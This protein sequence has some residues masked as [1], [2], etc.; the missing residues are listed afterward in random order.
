MKFIT[1]ATLMLSAGAALGK[2]GR[3]EFGRSKPIATLEVDRQLGGKGGKSSKRDDK[4]G[5]YSSKSNKSSHSSSKSMKSSHIQHV[6]AP[7]STPV[8]SNSRD[9]RDIKLA[10]IDFGVEE[11]AEAAFTMQT[12]P[13]L[14]EGIAKDYTGVPIA[15][16]DDFFSRTNSDTDEETR[17]AF[18]EIEDNGD[19]SGLRT[20]NM[21][22]GIA[23]L[24]AL[25]AAIAGVA[26]MR[27]KRAN[28]DTENNILD[29]VE[30]APV[31][32]A[33]RPNRRP[34]SNSIVAPVD[35]TDYSC[36]LFGFK[37]CLA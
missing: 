18:L 17:T 35:D 8:S 21:V 7:E 20:Q 24:F 25:L 27:N 23:S 31:A 37:D 16:Q 36:D 33:V 1:T 26:V 9:S 22:V 29:S 14:N 19:Y 4:A 32:P 2:E 6:S 12:Q 11:V 30:I 10:E 5:K 28:A 15:G 3:I 34:P 13:L